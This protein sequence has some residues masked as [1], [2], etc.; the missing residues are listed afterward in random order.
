MRS[1]KKTEAETNTPQYNKIIYPGNLYFYIKHIHK[2]III[3]SLGAGGRA[4]K[5]IAPFFFLPQPLL[6]V[7]AAG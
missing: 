3:F 4:L 1:G 2:Y 6:I 5:F 7:C